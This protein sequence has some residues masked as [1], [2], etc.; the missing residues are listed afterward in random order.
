MGIFLERAKRK[1][2]LEIHGTGKQRR[3]FVHVSDVV[4][5]LWAGW[6][7]EVQGKSLNVGTGTNI[8]IKELANKISSKQVHTERRKGDA[9]NTLADIRRI[10]KELNWKPEMPFDDG[11]D[12]LMREMGIAK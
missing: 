8:S 7:S 4:K 5:A 11:L 3:D 2:P 6:T 1:L 10:S 9:E 12:D